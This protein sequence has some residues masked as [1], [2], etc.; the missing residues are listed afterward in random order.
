MAGKTVVVLGAGV[1]GIVAANALRQRLGAEHR[2]VVVDKRGEHVFAPSLLWV[3]VG[4]RRPGQITK[5]VRRMLRPGVE[6]VLAEVEELQ[7][8]RSRVRAGGQELAYDYLIVALGADLAPQTLPGYADSAHNFFSLDGAT[9]LWKDLARFE[10]GRVLVLVSALPYKCP[11]APYEAAMLL[12][13]ALRRRNIRDR[14]QVE[15]FTPEMLPMPVAGPAMGE[16]VAQMLSAKDIRLHPKRQ[17][18]RIEP[19]S[20]ELVFV[21]GQRER[22]DFLAAVPPHRAPAVLKGSQLVNEAGW[23]QVD[24]H[25]LKTRYDNVYAVG[26]ATMITLANGKPLPKAGTFAHAEAEVVAERIAAAI[27]GAGS[28]AEFDGAGYCWLEAG[29]GSAGFTSGEFYAEP[30]PR[31]PLPRAGRMWHW[32]KVMFERYWLGDSLTR[33]ATRLGLRLGAKVFGIPAQL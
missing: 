31:V 18:Q 25:T 1:G 6:L 2:V 15:V 30:D 7:P 20:R 24:K 33:A 28:E 13:D 8:D 16:A 29:G 23:V 17:V 14:S 5:D 9:R 32:S 21:D 27:H 22:F 19:A 10:G 12:D 3:M 11:A 4:Q 26:D